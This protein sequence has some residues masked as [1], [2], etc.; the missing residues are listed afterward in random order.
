MKALLQNLD[1]VVFPGGKN[2]LTETNPVT[3][4]S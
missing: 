4:K 2:A 1:G 3:G